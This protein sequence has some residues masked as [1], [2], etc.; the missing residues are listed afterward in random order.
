MND[1]L[2]VGGGIGGLTAALALARAG[3]CVS[4]IERERSFSPVGAGIVLAP[5]AVAVLSRLGV[6]VGAHGE[7]VS[8]MRLCAAS[9]QTLQRMN[10]CVW[11]E[12][13]GPAYAFHRG[14]LHGAL[15][16]ALPSGVDLRLGG[17][18]SALRD[19][20]DS[21]EVDLANGRR[22]RYDLV[23]GADGIH[24][25]VRAALGDAPAVLYSGTTCWRAVCPNPG[26]R[27]TLEIWGQ[28]ARMGAVPLSGGR[29]YVFLVANAPRRAAAPRWPE[30]FRE[31]YGDFCQPAGEVLDALAGIQLLHHDL[32]ELERPVWGGGR[33]W[34][35]GDAA[36]AMTPNL[37]QGAAM[38]IEDALVLARCLGGDAVS[39]HARYVAE[40]H[41]R[42]RKVQ[43]DSRRLGRLAHWSSA[44][45]VW[46]RDSL[47][48][49]M[50]AA[51]GDRQYLDVVRPGLALALARAQ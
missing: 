35:L 12:S 32:E 17:T 43:L 24:S 44:A 20:G 50:P 4:L 3:A 21:V 37:G 1:I 7:R 31:I 33:V 40:R 14:D 47:F 2:V 46:I 11:A 45:A 49:L 39:A 29:L 38:A 42:V 51:V 25:A 13:H 41:P 6:D 16:D 15:L 27:E 18:V 5:N 9:G 8:G 48:R 22:E 10:L 28:G 34:L 36:H 19:T 30:G 26:V 23:V